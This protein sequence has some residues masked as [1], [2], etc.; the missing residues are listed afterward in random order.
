MNVVQDYQHR[1]FRHL[2]VVLHRDVQVHVIAFV[3]L[4]SAEPISLYRG[5]K[6]D[7]FYANY[8]A[9]LSSIIEMHMTVQ[10]PRL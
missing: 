1:C 7:V 4:R 5:V 10:D 2:A 9:F 3:M 6:N 8:K